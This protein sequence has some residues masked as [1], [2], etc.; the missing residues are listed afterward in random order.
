[1]QFFLNSQPLDGSSTHSLDELGILDGTTL[2]VF[3]NKETKGTSERLLQLGLVEE[4]P[5]APYVPRRHFKPFDHRCLGK[6]K[7]EQISEDEESDLIG[8]DNDL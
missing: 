8:G 3:D 2:E 7:P 1:M 5:F 4:D 6:K